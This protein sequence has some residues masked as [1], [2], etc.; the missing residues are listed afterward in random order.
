MDVFSLPVPQNCSELYGA[1]DFRTEFVMLTHPSTPTELASILRKTM[2]SIPSQQWQEMF[3][4]AAAQ[5]Q[6]A[7]TFF[8][9]TD[10][11]LKEYALW[12]GI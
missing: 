1:A 7:R 9:L 3:M 12:G 6:A 5:R 8:G 11:E 10:A 2:E 4:A